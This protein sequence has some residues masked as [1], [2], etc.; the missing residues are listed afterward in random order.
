MEYCIIFAILQKEEDVNH[1]LN[2]K[3][4][5][6]VMVLME[7]WEWGDCHNNANRSQ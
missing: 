7:N 5:K 4:Q 3:K 1:L 2:F 6:K